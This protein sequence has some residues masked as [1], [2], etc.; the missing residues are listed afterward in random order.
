MG[1]DPGYGRRRGLANLNQSGSGKL[2]GVN[3][4]VAAVDSDGRRRLD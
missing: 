4:A 1:N 2:V 3:V